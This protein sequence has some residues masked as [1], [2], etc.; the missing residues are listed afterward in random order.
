MLTIILPKSNWRGFSQNSFMGINFFTALPIFKSEM[1]YCLSSKYF[2][3]SSQTQAKINEVISWNKFLLQQVLLPLFQSV[4]IDSHILKLERTFRI[5]YL[6][7][8]FNLLQGRLRQKNPHNHLFINPLWIY[9]QYIMWL[10]NLFWSWIMLIVKTFIC[11]LLWNY[12]RLACDFHFR[13]DKSASF[14]K[15]AGQLYSFTSGKN[16][17]SQ[18]TVSH[19]YCLRHKI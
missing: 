9:R 10:S 2:V 12:H 6:N 5:R 14:S 3:S 7:L 8:L 13:L 18:S 15:T 16:L 4:F 19:H 17:I 11:F 1:Q